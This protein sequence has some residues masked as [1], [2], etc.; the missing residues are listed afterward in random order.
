MMLVKNTEN[1]LFEVAF[2]EAG[3]NHERTEYFIN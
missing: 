1:T 2:I 3:D